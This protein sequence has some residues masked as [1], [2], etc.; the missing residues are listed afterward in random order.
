MAEEKQNPVAIQERPQVSKGRLVRSWIWIWRALMSKDRI[1]KDAAEFEKRLRDGEEKLATPA[2][3]AQW[4]KETRE[5][6]AAL[7]HKFEERLK[8]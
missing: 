8:K 4:A 7:S 5:G 2:E 3:D 1:L 6:L